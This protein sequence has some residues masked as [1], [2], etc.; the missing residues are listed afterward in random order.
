MRYNMCDYKSL[1]IRDKAAC[2]Q[3]NK[4]YFI[5]LQLLIHHPEGTFKYFSAAWTILPQVNSM[6][7][8]LMG[9]KAL[10]DFQNLHSSPQILV[11]SRFK[12]ILV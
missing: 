3:Q 4:C 6:E 12:I 9:A 10:S 7:T 5:K 11:P 1:Y 8:L 2:P